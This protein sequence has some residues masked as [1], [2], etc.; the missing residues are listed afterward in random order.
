LVEL[1]RLLALATSRAVAE[2]EGGPVKNLDEEF[3]DEFGFV[4]PLPLSSS[5][6]QIAPED[7]PTGPAVG[8]ILPDFELPDS[9]GR[10][11]SL[12]SDRAGSRAAVVFFRSAVW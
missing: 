9:M 1:A 4:A 12:H 8:E 5:Q 11:V 7:F 2:R 6:R 3:E 10:L